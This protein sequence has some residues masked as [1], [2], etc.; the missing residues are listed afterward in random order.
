MT[1]I[2]EPKYNGREADWTG[3]QINEW[4]IISKIPYVEDTGMSAAKY[5]RTHTYTE[6]VSMIA[7][8]LRQKKK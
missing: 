8:K 5:Y 1:Q 2:G 4:K 6:T 3:V 7:S